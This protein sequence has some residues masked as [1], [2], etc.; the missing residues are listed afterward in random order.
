MRKYSLVEVWWDW[1]WDAN[2]AMTIVVLEAVAYIVSQSVKVRV[3]DG[4]QTLE[5]IVGQEERI[6]TR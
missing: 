5:G 6:A 1:L 2:V 4:R 3:H